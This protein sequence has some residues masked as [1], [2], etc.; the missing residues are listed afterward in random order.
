M[1]VKSI[2][3]RRDGDYFSSYKPADA[4]KPFMATLEVEGSHGK[5]ELRLSPELSAKIVAIVAEEIA[6][7]GRATAE[8]LTASC[9]TVEPPKP[10][11]KL[12]AA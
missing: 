3:I 10:A 12:V 4:S 2:N 1:I 5:V 9:L 7:A 8:A 6:A 11:K